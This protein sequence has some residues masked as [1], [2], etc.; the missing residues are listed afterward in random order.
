MNEPGE[1]DRPARPDAVAAPHP[2]PSATPSSTAS[3]FT[4]L[5]FIFF[6]SGCASLVY[7]VVW[8]RRLFLTLGS[9]SLAIATILSAFMGGLAL[10]SLV[11]GR[12]IDRRR[13][14]LTIYAI[15]E[16]AIG[17]Y[18]ALTPWLFGI[19]EGIFHALLQHMDLSL[20]PSYLV[21][22]ALAL[23]I[24]IVPTT[25]MGATLPVLSRQVVNHLGHFGRRLGV[26]YGINTFGAAFGVLITGFSL[27]T[28]L[29][30]NGTIFFA[31]SLNVLVSALAW[32]LDLALKG[33]P[34]PVPDPRCTEDMAPIP[35]SARPD[36]LQPADGDLRLSDVGLRSMNLADTHRWVLLMASLGG[37]ASFLYE[38]AWTRVLTLILGGAVQAFSVMLSTFLIGLA[39]GSFVLSR[40]IDRSR[41]LFLFYAILEGLIA[42]MALALLPVFG[43]LPWF[44]IRF[45]PSVGDRYSLLMLFQFV[46]CFLTLIVPTFLIGVTFPVVSKLYARD[47]GSLGQRIG[48]VYFANTAGGIFGSFAGGFVCIPLLGMERTCI[49]ASLIN[50]GSAMLAA[51]LSRSSPRRRASMAAAVA[52]AVF[53]ILV[54]FPVLWRVSVLDLPRIKDAPRPPAGWTTAVK[55][56]CPRCNEPVWFPAPPEK[57]GRLP[58]TAAFCAACAVKERRLIEDQLRLAPRWVWDPRVLTS[59]VH[60]YAREYSPS[61]DG[62]LLA[63]DL[64]KKH[65]IFYE[66]GL[67]A[68]VSVHHNVHSVGSRF[69]RVNGKTD[70]SNTADFP[71]EILIGA[72]PLLAHPNPQQ[73]IIIGLG[74]GITAG[75]VARFA[76][77][78]R[79]DLIEI[80]AAVVRAAR[81]FSENNHHVLPD[82][83]RNQPGDPRLRLVIQDARHFCAVTPNR[84]DVVVAEPSNPWM[85]GPS[86]LFTVEHFKNLRRIMKDDGLTIQWCQTYCMKP[87]L[88][89]SVIKTFRQVFEHVLVMT[90]SQIPGDLF[91]FGT[92]RPL[93]F[94]VDRFRDRFAR[95]EVLRNLERVGFQS[96][97]H[98]FAGIFLR[99]EDLDTNLGLRPGRPA[100]SETLACIPLNTD[101]FPYVEFEAPKALH[102]TDSTLEIIHALFRFRDLPIPPIHPDTDETLRALHLCLRLARAND[103]L[104]LCDAAS[105]VAERGLTVNP[106]DDELRGLLI[107]LNVQRWLKTQAP[108]LPDKIRAQAQLLVERTPKDPIPHI[109]LGELA[110][111]Q[112]RYEDA[113][114]HYEKALSLGGGGPNTHN[115]LGVAFTHLGRPEQASKSFERA[116]SLDPKYIPAYPALTDAYEKMGRYD[117]AIDTLMR[118][119]SIEQNTNLAN[120]ERV[121][122]RLEAIRQKKESAKPAPPPV[123]PASGP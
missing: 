14:Y 43:E 38:I 52:A 117:S 105:R 92:N 61:P 90:Y 28:S 95:P 85:S 57:D 83:A 36:T 78:Q 48:E 29:G 74:S 100:V 81:F 73:V 63:Q 49:L 120:Q 5:L 98:I 42:V 80:E 15:L 56:P 20:W 107:K 24:L 6:L 87:E 23:T 102:R 113:I 37:F 101:D 60:T 31:A 84:Y 19:A 82:P 86:H 17:I 3:A 93:S 44:Y 35:E 91:L 122:I 13:N 25:L 110:M 21:R 58:G 51:A 50:A 66:E 77:V 114:H 109:Q 96:V 8:T 97:T 89:Y 4:L 59:G 75:S 76:E 12:F 45:F 70:A 34:R 32:G 10:G 62:R 26:L 68:V 7:Q 123:P 67:N 88:V 18:G 94:D 2:T 119:Y 27:I 16:L 33:I 69:L 99:S 118:W 103:A 72:L 46:I 40:W 64:E 121:M 116:L 115:T 79:I 112:R 104:G 9:T 22:F 41:D 54:G 47:L 71:T 108:D 106:Q 55:A 11:A 65:L 39:L 1:T 53:A 111:V 30:I